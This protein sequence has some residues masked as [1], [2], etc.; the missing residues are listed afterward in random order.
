MD[1][2]AQAASALLRRFSVALKTH[3][4]YP[5]PSQLS[6]RAVA[7]VLEGL[8][9]YVGSYG[10]FMVR[11]SK[12]SFTV[13]GATFK[14]AASSNLAFHLYTRRVIGFTVMPGVTSDELTAFLS[15]VRMDRARLEGDGG[16]AQLVMQAGVHAIKVGEIFLTVD[17]TSDTSQ[18]QVWD[19][20]SDLLRDGR[21]SPEDREIVVDAL[22]AGPKATGALLEKLHAMMG[23]AA[24]PGPSEHQGERAYRLVQNLDRL[25][26]NEPVEDHER[27]YTSL[28]AGLVLLGEP[29]R[30]SMQDTLTSHADDDETARLLLNH[31]SGQRLEGI[32]TSAFRQNRAVGAEAALAPNAGAASRQTAVDQLIAEAGVHLPEVHLEEIASIDEAW[33]TREVIGTLVDTF[34]N[35]DSDSDLTEAAAWLEAHLPWLVE[36]QEFKF[37][38]TVLHALKEVARKSASHGKVVPGIVGG[39]LKDRPLRQMLEAFWREPETECS[40][41]IRACLEMLADQAVGSL[42]RLLGEEPESSV[43]R[44]LCDVL[45]TIATD[46]TDGVGRFISDTRWYL[47]RN[48]VHV[49]GRL[50]SAK[51]IVYLDQLMRHPEYRVRREVVE[52]LVRIGTDDAEARIVVFLDDPNEGIRL[53]AVLSLS[54]DGLR[55]AVP[56]LLGLLEWPDAW[57]QQ[58]LVKQEVIAAL[59]RVRAREAVPVLSRIARRRF[60]LGSRR[61]RL[62]HLAQDALAMIESD[63]QP[64][65]RS[66]APMTTEAGRV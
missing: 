14:D 65:E 20:L 37:L 44:A 12:R 10:P 62:R 40:E 19:G 52:A 46:Q 23:D 49:L 2:K 7:E 32:P 28:A 16:V 15:V 43:R 45:V 66:M 56:R 18:D 35:L 64:R 55:R 21:L 27:L 1:T 61:R 29:V 58:Y 54:D 26:L 5:P 57:S 3:V 6:D 36:Q 11:V 53:K 4:L 41:A 34:R 9:R 51:A 42:M 38:R 17:D 31:L 33:V 50:G 13:E 47:V 22:R 8:H 63:D 24:D 39:V 30:K 60:V 25:I 59:A 48:A